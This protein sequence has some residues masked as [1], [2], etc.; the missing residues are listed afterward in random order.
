MFYGAGAGGMQTASAVLGDVVSA[1]RRHVVGGP[2]V[3]ESTHANL[4]VLP[5][6]RS[7]PATRSPSRSPTSRACSRPIATL[8]SD[9]RR[10]GRDRRA[11][12]QPARRPPHGQEPPSATATLVIG[13]HEATEAALA[14]HR[15]GPR[16]ERRRQRGRHPFCESKDR[17][18]DE[19]SS[20][21][22]PVARSP[23]RIR[24]P[25]RRHGRHTDHHARRG[26]HAAASRAARSRRAPARTSGS[27]SRG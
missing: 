6:A 18:L 3:A 25:A 15:G 22:S 12:G 21:T 20:P 14:R 23:A 19:Y 16:R 1:A 11:V 10:L 24:G 27:S 9:A 8:F 7:P 4:P 5:I 17:K 2:G 26:R 13:T